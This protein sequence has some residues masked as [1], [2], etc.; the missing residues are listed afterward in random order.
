MANK[1]KQTMVFPSSCGWIRDQKTN[2][3]YFYL[4][5]QCLEDIDL[6]ELLLQEL[7]EIDPR[8]D[9]EEDIH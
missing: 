6:L 1:K 7:H 2:E 8:N 4:P 3:L 9:I 5:A